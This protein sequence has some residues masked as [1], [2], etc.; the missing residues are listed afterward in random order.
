MLPEQ[1][2]FEILRELTARIHAEERARM[3]EPQVFRLSYSRA[4]F[5]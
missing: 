1:N 3:Q 2:G 4:F 5:C